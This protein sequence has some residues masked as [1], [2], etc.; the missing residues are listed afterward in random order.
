[1]TYR[2]LFS[3]RLTK[4]AP[5]LF[6]VVYLRPSCCKPSQPA[7]PEFS[8][9]GPVPG[10]EY[11]VR[12]FDGR[13]RTPLWRA[14]L[15]KFADEARAEFASAVG[16]RPGGLLGLEVAA[17]LCYGRHPLV[18]RQAEYYISPEKAFSRALRGWRSPDKALLGP[19]EGDPPGEARPEWSSPEECWLKLEAAGLI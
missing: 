12:V 16:W 6:A 2:E 4:S 14:F 19:D 10:L 8:D 15:A 17:R 3:R 5:G 11:Q 1:M 9:A 13:R 7:R 18:S